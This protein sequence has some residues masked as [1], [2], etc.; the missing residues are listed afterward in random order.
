QSIQLRLRLL[1]ADSGLQKSDRCG[2]VPQ[3]AIR[4]RERNGSESCRYPYFDI[5]LYCAAR[6]PE[7]GRKNPDNRVRIIVEL[8]LSPQNSG[9]SAKRA[10]PQAIAD[11]DRFCET[12]RLV[13]R[14][15]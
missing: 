3:A 13:T 8:H 4:F 14:P 2:Q 6:M 5:C 15:E 11:H 12:L 10:G 7:S 9:I 1:Q